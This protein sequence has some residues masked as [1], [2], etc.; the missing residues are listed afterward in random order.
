MRRDLRHLQSVLF[1][2]LGLLAD[3]HIVET[4]EDERG[5]PH[6]GVV[7]WLGGAFT[8]RVHKDLNTDVR[9]AHLNVGEDL[10]EQLLKEVYG[11]VAVDERSGFRFFRAIFLFLSAS[12]LSILQLGDTLSKVAFELLVRSETDLHV[13]DMNF[14][15][16]G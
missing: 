14:N 4:L 9:D 11:V 5:N 16:L 12:T 7:L 1:E 8:R 6:H 2:L 15:T 13:A 3:F 10:L